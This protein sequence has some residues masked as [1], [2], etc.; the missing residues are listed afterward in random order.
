ME[1]SQEV[2]VGVVTERLDVD[3]STASRVRRGC[4]GARRAVQWR[5][6]RRARVGAGS[7][8][9]N[10]AIRNEDAMSTVERPATSAIAYLS[11]EE[12]ASAY[13]GG[14]LSPVEATTTI[15]ERINRLNPRLH[16]FLHVDH[17]GALAA[18]RESE[19]R[20]R[21][22][23]ARGPL[24]GVPISIKDL[25][26]V[27]GLPTTSGS[28]VYRGVI[29]DS[30][31]IAT[32]RLRSAGAVILG[33]TNTPEFGLLPS[34]ENELG[35]D[36]RNPWDITRTSGGSSGGSASAAAAGLGP[37]H[38]GTDGGG[39]IRIPAAF[40][41]IFGLKPTYG[42]VAR[43]GMSGMPMFSHTGPL[44]R[45]IADAALMM[46]AMSGPDPRDVTSIPQPPPAFRA[47]LD[48]ALGRPRVALWR[49]PWDAPC[50]PEITALV[51]A[52]ARRFEEIGCVVEEAGPEA[53]DPRPIFITIMFADEYTV[54]A[55]LLA[56][57]RDLLAPYTRATLEAGAKVTVPEY[58]RALRALERFKFAMR[59]FF[60]NY[61]L[62]LMPVTA[63]PAFP[64]GQRPDRIAG[65]EVDPLGGGFPYTAGFNLTSQP[66]ASIPC[67]FTS[68]G[69]PV[70]LQVVAR[71][72][73]EV[74]LLR[75]C[76]AFEQAQPWRNRVPNVE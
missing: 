3:P 6:H 38:A 60:E 73:D 46:D 75:A 21:E 54:G 43:S 9:R 4:A 61:D 45:T 67:G 29:A 22:G 64:I 2:T 8:R 55:E 28:A 63:I 52:A 41:G 37:L 1:P 14:A 12:L 23:T 25:L 62:L 65:R 48:E 47:A 66:A 30:D 24:E 27:K 26:D 15:L 13:R 74:T 36:C 70:G 56:N 50:E 31:S 76:A 18:A 39:S 11:A 34:T 53:E 58:S 35:E 16:A 40:C 59:T 19:A 71:W 72:G 57:Q 10:P 7:I 17:E 68:E 69:L 42:R 5:P 51:T 32:E 49:A 44:T 20:F 33:K